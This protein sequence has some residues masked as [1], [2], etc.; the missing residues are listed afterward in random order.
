MSRIKEHYHDIITKPIQEPY[1]SEPK[2]K[3]FILESLE[4]KPR[5]HI[6]FDTYETNSAL[7]VSLYEDEQPYAMLSVNIPGAELLSEGEFY[8]K[9]YSENQFIAQE[10]IERNIL[11][12]ANN[13]AVTG[14]ATVESYT[15]N[16]N[17]I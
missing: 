6:V 16:P 12:P 11:I 17:Y 3:S 4:D 2:D 5:V 1:M 14:F 13:T 9:A 7:A 15:V 8:L 10:L